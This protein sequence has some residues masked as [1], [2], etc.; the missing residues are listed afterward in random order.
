MKDTKRQAQYTPRAMRHSERCAVCKYYLR[1]NASDGDCDKVEGVV[2]A[3][4]WCK[5]WKGKNA[6]E[7]T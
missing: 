6:R 7:E 1:L 3:A 4:G 2:K 5:H